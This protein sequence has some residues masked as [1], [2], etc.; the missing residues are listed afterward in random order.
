MDFAHYDNAVAHAQALA[1]QVVADRL[2]KGKEI[3]VKSPRS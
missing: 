1:L 3:N 2:E